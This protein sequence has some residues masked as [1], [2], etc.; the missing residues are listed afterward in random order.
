MT[1]TIVNGPL[2]NLTSN[3][4]EGTLSILRMLNSM[5]GRGENEDTPATQS[6]I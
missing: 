3:N 6:Q 1:V 5:M 2:N 4:R